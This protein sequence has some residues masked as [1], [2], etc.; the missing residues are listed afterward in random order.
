MNLKNTSSLLLVLVALL[1]WGEVV[2]AFSEEDRRTMSASSDEFSFPSSRSEQDALY[3][4]A[5][6]EIESDAPRRVTLDPAKK[7]Y[8]GELQYTF[9]PL[10]LDPAKITFFRP[11]REQVLK[12][13]KKFL[14][15]LFE[16]LKA[17]KSDFLSRDRAH[18]APAILKAYARYSR[19]VVGWSASGAEYVYLKFRRESDHLPPLDREYHVRDG[20]HSYFEFQCNLTKSGLFNVRVHGEA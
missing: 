10:M 16:D 14:E 4:R 11:T 18:A 6:K 9:H 8:L 1:L 7:P 17:G 12:C 19:Q 15:L 5:L 20:G 13:E 3:Q 2:G